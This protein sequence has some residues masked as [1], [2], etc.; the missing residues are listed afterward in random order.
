MITHQVDQHLLNVIK[1]LLAS[2]FLTISMMTMRQVYTPEWHKLRYNNLTHIWVRHSDS[3]GG[4]T[5]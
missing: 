5:I 2:E 1:G 3:F 4:F